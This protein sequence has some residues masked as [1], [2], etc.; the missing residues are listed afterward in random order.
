MARTPPIEQP[1]VADTAPA[2][3]P[4]DP[5]PAESR[6]RRALA[7][8][9]HPV[10][11]PFWVLVGIRVAF[12]FGTALTFLWEPIDATTGRDLANP[13]WEARSD[14]LL[15]TFAHWDA[16]WYLLIAREGYTQDEA[17]AFFPLYPLTTHA[18]AWVTRSTVAAGVLVA[19]VAA[20]I[21]A[22]CVHT[23]ARDLL[24]RRVADDSV[25]LLALYPLAFVFTAVYSEGLFLALAAGSLLAARRG[26]GVVA[27]L[28][29]AGAVATRPSASPSS[30]RC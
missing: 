30:P 10:A 19:L 4:E 27:A 8:V 3:A 1:P 5:R 7:L 16:G 20:G 22:A 14:L 6:I 17:A 28:L 29:G 23:L 25:I 13:G 18:V 11:R 12:L 21:G 9:A 15:N 2:G 24:N 26:H